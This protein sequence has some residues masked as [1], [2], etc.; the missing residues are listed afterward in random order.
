MNRLKCSLGYTTVQFCSESSGRYLLARLGIHKKAIVTG[1]PMDMA[2]RVS[3]IQNNRYIQLAESWGWIFGV[4]VKGAAQTVSTLG[5]GRRAARPSHVPAELEIDFNFSAIDCS[6]SDIHSAWR[7]M[8]NK[9]DIFWTPQNGGHWVVTRAEHIAKVMKTPEIF[10][11]DQII[12]PKGAKPIKLLPLEARPDEHG[13]YRAI[14]A[15]RLTPKAVMGMREGVR[16]IAI[17]IIDGFYA[18]GE[19][20]FVEDFAKRFPI[21]V[22]LQLVDLPQSDR[23]KLLR[24][25]E[26]AVRSKLPT[27]ILTSFL[28]VMNYLEYWIR[29]RRREPGDDL[30]SDIVNAKIDGKPL[31]HNDIQSMLTVVLFGGLDTVA[32]I[33]GFTAKFLAENPEH[34]QQLIDNPSL[35]PK[36]IDEILRLHGIVNLSRYV[37]ED[38]ELGGVLMKKG[39]MIQVPNGLYGVDDRFISDPL[40]VDFNRPNSAASHAAFGMGIHRCVGSTL[41]RMEITVFL[42]EWLSRIPNFQIE[43][44]QSA[45]TVAGQVNGIEKLPLSWSSPH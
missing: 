38:T 11:S 28:H 16:S 18:R 20:E 15:K 34:R 42:E 43:P 7:E 9:P 8:F 41:A 44:G 45:I 4:V 27:H 39:D 5:S 1:I 32:A 13:P 40:T 31:S 22:F 17:E 3:K 25:T 10:S 21:A 26:A 30:I 19:C 2:H 36:A 37:A 12:L 23:E 33:L 6:N 14:I 35:I 29:E 24:W